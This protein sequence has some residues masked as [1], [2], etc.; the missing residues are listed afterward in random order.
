MN[1]KMENKLKNIRIKF[2]TILTLM[3]FI[4]APTQAQVFIMD[5]DVNENSRI[6]GSSFVIPPVP[7]QGADLDEYVPLGNGLFL[8]LGLGS[9]Y[10]MKKRKEE[11]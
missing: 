10:M 4:V 9:V 6:G 11:D 1:L 2:I 3:L 7:Y 5:E 8:L